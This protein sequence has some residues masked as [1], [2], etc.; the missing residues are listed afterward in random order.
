MSQ[1]FDAVFERGV[2]RP[3]EQIDLPERTKVHLRIQEAAADT[4]AP[5][6]EAVSA[7]NAA[8]QNLLDWVQ[9]RPKSVTGETVSARDHDRMLYDWKK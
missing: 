1:E 9:D 4:P 8:L 7:Q 6:T 2:F 3:L 5:P